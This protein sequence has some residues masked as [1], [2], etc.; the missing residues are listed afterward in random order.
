MIKIYGIKT[1]GSVKKALQ[2]FQNNHLEYHFQ[3]FK[4]DPVQQATIRQWLSLTSIDI[5]LNTK[6]TTYKTL[7]LKAM[8]LNADEKIVWMSTNNLLIKRP[9][10]EFKNQL[11]IGFD[12]IHYKEVFLP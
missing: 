1:C 2:F 10:I 8:G 4:S 12:E 7:G 9:V 6:G 11:I 5:L 3:D